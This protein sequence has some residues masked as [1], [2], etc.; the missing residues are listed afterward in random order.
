MIV[1]NFVSGFETICL[2]VLSYASLAIEC[3]SLR[4]C[5]VD[6]VLESVSFHKLVPVEYKEQLSFAA[7]RVLDFQRV[8]VYKENKKLLIIFLLDQINFNAEKFKS[9]TEIKSFFIASYD[10]LS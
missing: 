8:I 9:Y 3:S 10:F 7:H 1:K 2:G 5:P 4:A 6:S